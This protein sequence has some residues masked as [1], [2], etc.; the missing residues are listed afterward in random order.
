MQSWMGLGTPIVPVP[1]RLRQDCE[2]E[3]SLGYTA[4]ALS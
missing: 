3:V 2:F 1:G 4:E